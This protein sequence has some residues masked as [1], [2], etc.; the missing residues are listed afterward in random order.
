MQRSICT[1]SDNQCSLRRATYPAR[2]GAL[3]R[4]TRAADILRDGT[5]IL[6]DKT[7]HREYSLCMTLNAKG[8]Q[9]TR[10]GRK[11]PAIFQLTGGGTFPPLVK[12]A[13]AM[14]KDPPPAKNK[15]APSTASDKKPPPKIQ[16]KLLHW[17]LGPSATSTPPLKDPSFESLER[18]A[19]ATSV[20]EVRHPRS[21]LEGP[22]SSEP[23]SASVLCTPI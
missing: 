4:R 8:G 23:R 10:R 5:V 22:F 20:P 16:A 2:D 17:R 1:I 13:A 6:F 14:K 9:P 19:P 3:L 7:D 21:L 12:P 11:Q 15:D 18:R